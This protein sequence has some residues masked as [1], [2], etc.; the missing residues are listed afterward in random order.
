MFNIIFAVDEANGLG[1]SNTIPWKCTN[2]MKFF[3]RQTKGNILIVGKKTWN[4]MP[5]QKI[6]KDRNV[7][8]VSRSLV[9]SSECTVVAKS[10]NDALTIAYNNA[11]KAQKVFV[12]GG[13]QLYKEAVYHPDC[14]EIFVSFIK[15]VHKCDTVATFMVRIFEN[16]QGRKIETYD[17]CVIYQY[18][19]RP[20]T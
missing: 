19:K 18:T 2:D 6:L 10:F 13:L 7:I 4:S 16:F 5:Q 3:A 9:Q 11:H 8:V 14:T 20:L 15:G 17:D 1:N 12:I